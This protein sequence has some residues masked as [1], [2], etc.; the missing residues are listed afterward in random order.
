MEWFGIFIIFISTPICIRLMKNKEKLPFCLNC[1]TALGEKENYCPSCGQENWDQKVPLKVFIADF[2]S[3]YFNFDSTFFKTAPVFLF[4]PGK[5][6]NTYNG[7][8]RRVYLNPIRLYL[9]MSLFYFFAVSLIIPRNLFDRVMA[10]DYDYMSVVRDRGILERPEV[11]NALSKQEKA[12]LD[13]L[14]NQ[15]QLK[16]PGILSGLDTLTTNLGSFTKGKIGWRALKLLA[17]D[18]MVSDSA[19]GRAVD[20]SSLNGLDFVSLEGKR[21]FVANSNLFLVGFARNLPVMMLFLLPFFALMLKLLYIRG[22]WYYVEHLI[23]GLHLH[24]FAYLIYGIGIVMI[25]LKTVNAEWVSVISFV[26]VSAYTYISLL[27][28]YKQGW[29][30]TFLKFNVLGFVYFFLFWMALSYELYLSLRF[31]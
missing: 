14:L 27:N 20:N 13:S 30:K 12:E 4:K 31:L 18:P 15:A 10:G 23:H 6:S 29:F 3:T 1:G 9:V 25:H 8:K 11:K 7:G 26:I 22:P 19:F 5:L 17:Q 16:N 2:F 24:S 21:N 28:V